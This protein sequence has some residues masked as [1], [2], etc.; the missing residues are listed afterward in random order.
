MDNNKNDI[1]IYSLSNI[2]R[3]LTRLSNIGYALFTITFTFLSIIDAIIFSLNLG[4]IWKLWI[5]IIRRVLISVFF[6][7][8]IINL[9]NWGIYSSL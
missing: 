5:S 3:I 9:R 2:Q 1:Y 4:N 6:G 8:N 7:V